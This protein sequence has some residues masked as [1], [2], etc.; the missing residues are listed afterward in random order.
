[1]L[2]QAQRQIVESIKRTDMLKIMIGGGN[3][4]DD[5]AVLLCCSI[6]SR[7]I[8]KLRHDIAL[9]VQDFFSQE[10][11]KEW[12]RSITSYSANSTAGCA[13]K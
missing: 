9:A 5:G 4:E 10:N 2:D 7:D 12:K 3:L 1:M 11:R 13:R 8:R 6:K